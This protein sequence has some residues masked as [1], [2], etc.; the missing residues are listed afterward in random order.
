M[1]RTYSGIDFNI[2]N[3]RIE[4]ID[5]EDIAESLS[6]QCR[7]NGHCKGFYSV[8]QH[9][10]LVS[11][12]V[13]NKLWGLLHDAAEAY[14]GDIVSP[15]KRQLPLVNEIEAKIL[16]LIAQ[17][18]NLPW[19]IPPEIE[20]VD[21]RMYDTEARDL[22]GGVGGQPYPELV[23]PLEICDLVKDI[24]LERFRRYYETV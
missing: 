8:A 1:M 10:I 14:I 19:P 12:K 4:D 22:M 5:I 13:N 18:Y 6:K 11:E 16:K 24:F 20:C 3:P 15:L 2:D 23:I 17:K 7:F 9:S 21:I